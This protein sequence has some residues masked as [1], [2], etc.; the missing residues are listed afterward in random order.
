MD[1]SSAPR[2]SL[3]FFL[4]LSVVLLGMLRSATGT[5]L[6]S[7]TVDEPWHIVAGTTYARG[8]GFHLN[9][10]H[11]PLVKLW[12]GAAMPEAFRL[13]AP[14][15]LSEKTQE[16]DWVE[17][18]LFFDNDASAAQARARVAMWSLHGILLL[19]LGLLLWR[20]FGLAWA[21]GSLGFLAIDPTVAA[22]LPVVMTDL[23]LALTLL[24]AAIAAGLV[25]ATWRWPWVIASGA[26]MGLALGAKHSALAGLGGIGLG[27][28]LAAQPGWRKGAREGL[29]RHLKLAAAALLAV[30]V[31]WS[32][33]GLRFHAGVDGSDAY[34]RPMADKI[35]ELQLPHWREG[36]AFADR[37][38]LLPRPYL[39]GLAD[40]VRT[41]VEG[42]GLGMH[43]VWG[44][45]YYG[46]PPW[47]SWPAILASKLPLALLVLLLA[48]LP[49]LAR[50]ALPPPARW[51]LAAVALGCGFHMIALVGSD[52]IWGGVRHALPVITSAAVLAGGVLAWA[53]QR[54]SRPALAA[55][56]ALYVA[57]IAMTI[58]E[59][60]LWE[61]HNELVGGTENAHRYFTNEGL[62]L[63]QRFGE[64]RAFHDR[65]ISR[66][67]EP[68]YV[69]YW[70]GEQQIR[71]A[72]MRYSRRV[73]SLQD[74]N[75]TGVYR[76]WF[77]YSMTETL[78]WPQW[79]WDPQVVFKDMRLM[80]RFGFVQVWHGEMTRPQTRAG[81]MFAKVS[82]YIYKEGGNDWPLV[83]ARLE[84]VVA[85]LPAKVDAGVE[86]GNAYLRLGRREQAIAAYQRLLDQDKVPVEPKIARQ[87]KAHISAVRHAPDPAEV[88]PFRNPWLE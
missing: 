54:R 85:Q 62:D 32:M 84:E 2:R 13:R 38:Q 34:N 58:R 33:Y 52:G 43:F 63:G 1:L 55:V 14:I 11:P 77:V 15:A 22:H 8:G 6:D 51:S 88:T 75:V 47:F 21:A 78:P 61:Y 29:R 30:A 37:H 23:P 17:Q 45:V 74:T 31:L 86:L 76:G 48:S 70:M 87:L 44:K 59:P 83:A 16:R 68:L 71:A 3:G 50:R 46:N 36:I 28:L 5:R 27:L 81:S 20:A 25:A 72:R 53:W 82:D 49:L 60:R 66:S 9:P 79:D 42:R 41:G 10:E 39:W 65:V 12:V 69:D 56:A 80:A 57:A 19:A 64:V 24:I 7:F 35:A 67:G 4:L 26:A 73:E 18:T 40:T